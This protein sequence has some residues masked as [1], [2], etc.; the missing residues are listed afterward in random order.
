MDNLKYLHNQKG[1][2]VSIR[3]NIDKTNEGVYSQIAAT[4]EKEL[5][6]M[7]VY[8][9]FVTGG[10]N[11]CSG[12]IFTNHIEKADFLIQQYKEYE[13]LSLSYFPS[14]SPGHCMATDFNTWIVGPE[15]ELYNCQAEVGVPSKVVG[16]IK[17]S[18]ITNMDYVSEFMVGVSPFEN[19]QCRQCAVLPLCGGGCALDRINKKNGKKIDTCAVFKDKNKLGELIKQVEI[20]HIFRDVAPYPTKFSDISYNKLL[21]AELLFDEMDKKHTFELLKKVLPDQYNKSMF[22][23]EM[24]EEEIGELKVALKPVLK[25]DLTYFQE[26]INQRFEKKS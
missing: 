24:Q 11:A 14:F 12:K 1:I 10:C 7:Y 2:S 6:G 25:Y 3:V 26:R 15:G 8:P 5:P 16:N 13:N 21:I 20:G 9:G 18:A 22:W 17:E 4:I 19:K 23:L